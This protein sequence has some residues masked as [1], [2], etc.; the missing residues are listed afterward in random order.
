[1]LWCLT[2]HHCVKDN[3][4]LFVQPALEL[5]LDDDTQSLARRRTRRPNRQLPRRFRDSLPEPPM[6]LPPAQVNPEAHSS[7]FTSSPPSVQTRLQSL[8]PSLRRMFKTQVNSFGLYRVYNATHLPTHDPDDAYAIE[9]HPAV[10]AVNLDSRN[11]YRPY[12]NQNSFRLGEWYWNHGA[13]KSKESFKKLLDIVGSVAYLPED[14]RGTNWRAIDDALGGSSQEG[15]DAEWL[16]EDDNW[17]STP[18]SI[19]VPFHSRCR[20]PG[21][22]DYLA[23]NFH[24]RSLVSIIREKLSDPG[25]DRLFHYE[26][27]ELK[28]RPPHTEEDI[29]VHG[30]LFTSDAFIQAHQRLQD[31]PPE[32]GC[33]LPKVVAGLMF[34]SDSTQLSTFGN[35]KLWPLYLYFGNESKYY[36][37]QPTNNLCTHAA[38]F[39]TVRSSCC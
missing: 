15:R 19:S 37:C 29:R 30:E 18:I 23:G 36:R 4:P 22:K 31:S 10:P 14:I 20:N 17:R 28:W 9:H 34:W 39:Q 33:D 16:D 8:R 3:S 1:M 11:P 25:H 35:A 6:P 5:L 21:P 2:Y 27:Y 26:P 24:H 13:H 32:P 7:D 12:P 38:Y